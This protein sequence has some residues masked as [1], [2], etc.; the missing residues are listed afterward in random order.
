MRI[1]TSMGTIQGTM[2]I[3]S[4]K[5]GCLKSAWKYHK[6]GKWIGCGKGI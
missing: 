5:N 6:K 2:Q 4:E 1:R 3:L